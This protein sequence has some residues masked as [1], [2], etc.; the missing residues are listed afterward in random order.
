MQHLFT[1]SRLRSTPRGFT[2]VELLVVIAII[3]ALM[4]LLLPAVQAARESARR[5]QCRNHLKQLALGVLLVEDTHGHLPTGGW[6]RYWMVDPRRGPG[7]DQPGGWLFAT[8]PFLE[9]RPLHDA[10]VVA[11]TD[12]RE[13]LTT[14]IETP[15]P[16]LHCPSRRP[17]KRYGHTASYQNLPLAPPADDCDDCWPHES[18]KT[19]YAACAGVNWTFLQDMPAPNSLAEGDNTF[20]WQE[21]PAVTHSRGVVFARSAVRIAEI[22]DGTT[23]TILLGE[24]FL[25]TNID[26]M[27]SRYGDDQN[28]YAGYYCNVLRTT[29]TPPRQDEYVK[30]YDGVVQLV[31]F[32]FGSPHPGGCNVAMC[33]GSVHGVSYDVDEQLFVNL[34]DRRDGEAA[35]VE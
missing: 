3:G 28:P 1:Q 13:S 12:L 35:S 23:N 25:R 15:L 31:D 16:I 19:D 11:E 24:K 9:Q 26:E 18:A 30:G 7:R 21:Q 2:L 33:D 10:S 6:G 8:L 32:I 5:T 20:R 34:G 4:S 22:T 29:R 27:Y 14:L 17:A